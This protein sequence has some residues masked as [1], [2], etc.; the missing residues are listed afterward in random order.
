[1]QERG[2]GHREE[3]RQAWW[4]LA[5]GDGQMISERELCPGGSQTQSWG[6]RG[7]M[8]A[9]TNVKAL[10]Q[11]WKWSLCSDLPRQVSGPDPGDHLES[12]R[13]T[14]VGS[15]CPAVGAANPLLRVR[16]GQQAGG[17]PGA[18]KSA[19]WERSC[20]L[21]FMWNILI[22]TFWPTRETF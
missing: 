10:K 5:D 3:S 15:G 22:F 9:G 14:Q 7:E 8:W 12:K 1:M 2:S 6:L 20:K 16:A 21:G 19:R 11:V 18:V 17:P 13:P 4:N